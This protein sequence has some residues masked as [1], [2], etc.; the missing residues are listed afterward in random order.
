MAKEVGPDFIVMDASSQYEGWAF[1]TNATPPV[2]TIKPY[3][4][5]ILCVGGSGGG[6]VHITETDGGKTIL[7]ALE[8][9]ADEEQIYTVNRYVDGIWSETIDTGVKVIFNLGYY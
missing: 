9:G 3:I 2:I 4:K 5:D 6:T 7:P 1:R 8:V